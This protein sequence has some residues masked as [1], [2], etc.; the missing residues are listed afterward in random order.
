MEMNYIYNEKYHVKVAHKATSIFGNF[1]AIPKGNESFQMTTWMNRHSKKDYHI[2]FLVNKGYLCITGDLGEGILHAEDFESLHD[3]AGLSPDY[4]IE[5]ICC[6]SES[7]WFETKYF[8]KDFVSKADLVAIPENSKEMDLIQELASFCEDNPACKLPEELL[9]KVK[10]TFYV[11]SAELK[12]WLPCCGRRY[13]KRIIYWQTALSMMADSK[14]RE[15][16]R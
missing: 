3:W 2:N 1:V 11:D 14:L 15:L 4:F 5:K 12:D 7:P 9:D 13:P 6:T 8:I 10:Q 16:I